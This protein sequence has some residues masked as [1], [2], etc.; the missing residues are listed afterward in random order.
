MTRDEAVNLAWSIGGDVA[1]LVV[2]V[3]AA[4]VGLAVLGSW[5]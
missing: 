4:L 5:R 3:A 1:A 2:F